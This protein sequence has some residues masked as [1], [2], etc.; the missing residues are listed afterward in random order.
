M[1]APLFFTAR[2]F[3]LAPLKGELSPK[4][5]EG[6]GGAGPYGFFIFSARSFRIPPNSA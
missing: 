1:R 5:T 2:A 4:A 3:Y 6:S